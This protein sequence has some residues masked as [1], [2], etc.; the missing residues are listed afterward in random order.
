MLNTMH[1]CSGLLLVLVKACR[2]HLFFQGI[3]IPC[4][5]QSFLFCVLLYLTGKLVW[6]IF[7]KVHRNHLNIRL[8][9]V[10]I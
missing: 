2:L 6:K 8:G 5:I 9:S 10:S 3:F 4:V 1:F 7:N